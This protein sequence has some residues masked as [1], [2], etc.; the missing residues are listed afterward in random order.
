MVA[1]KFREGPVRVL[2][3]A[4]S[5]NLGPGFDSMGLALGV[6]DEYIA[7]VTEDPGVLVEV[8][9]EGSDA[10]PRDETHLVV[11]A[12]NIAFD[13]MGGRP[14]GFVLRCNNTIPH[15]KGLGSS[16]AAL[17]GGMVLARAMVNGEELFSDHDLLT[18]ALVKES[19]PDN[20][21]AALFGGLTVAWVDDQGAAGAI[22]R[23]VHPTLRCLVAVPP[24]DLPTKQARIALAPT[25]SRDDAVHNISRSA[26]LLHALTVDPS[27]LME[28]T[29]DR[30]HQDARSDM[31]P[32][33]MGLIRTLREA[34]IAAAIS[35]AGPTVLAFISSDDQVA[36]VHS[37]APETWIVREVAIASR[38]AHEVPLQP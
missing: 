32:E 24:N 9:G 29:T 33:S 15:G 3:P 13:H 1:P 12:M 23:D 34:G 18:W 2:V 7:M 30:L 11:Q 28:A 26:L 19:H 8:M 21:S 16:A 38:G 10:V 4:S 36:H 27:Y 35:G 5:A 14:P 17:M 6:V 25:V 37:V 31:Y 20:L 22:S